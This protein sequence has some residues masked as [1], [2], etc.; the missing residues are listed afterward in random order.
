MLV[1]LLDLMRVPCK[2]VRERTAMGE[3]A[4]WEIAP[5]KKA[6]ADPSSHAR[7]ARVLLVKV[8]PWV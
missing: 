8:K 1:L 7:M 2:H 4:Q 5:C 3:K 6:N